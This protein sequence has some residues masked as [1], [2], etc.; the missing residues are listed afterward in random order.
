MPYY[1]GTVGPR[2]VMRAAGLMSR[3][4]QAIWI[5]TIVTMVLSLASANMDPG[6]H[7][8]IELHRA[9]NPNGPHEVDISVVPHLDFDHGRLVVLVR[10]YDSSSRF[11]DTLWEGEAHAGDTISLR[12]VLPMLETG[13]FRIA[14][15]IEL[16]QNTEGINQLG[17]GQLFVHIEDTAVHTSRGGF[18]PIDRQRI[19]AELQ[20]IKPKLDSLGIAE[21]TFAEVGQKA[22]W[23]LEQV[24][25]RIGVVDFMM[26]A[27]P[28]D[29]VRSAE[30]LEQK[31]LSVPPSEVS[32]L[33]KRRY[34][35]PTQDTT[36]G[37]P[38]R[39]L[40]K[41]LDHDSLEGVLNATR[42]TS[43]KQKLPSEPVVVPPRDIHA[44]SLERLE[45][46]AKERAAG[47]KLR[48]EPANQGTDSTSAPS[49]RHR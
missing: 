22:P 33:A 46:I 3:P 44:D 8:W 14:T 6:G 5:G 19:H 16:P 43:L 30:I 40:R 49:P 20:R 29:S 28:H 26:P 18:G 35:D 23:I 21:A 45:N 39:L 27:S 42:P 4:S 1:R 32:F 10:P 34:Y 11:R 7:G 9:A 17:G 15:D 37:I 2:Y 24:Q 12:Y 25:E 38:E 48:G 36:K 47:G 13:R 41:P 31:T